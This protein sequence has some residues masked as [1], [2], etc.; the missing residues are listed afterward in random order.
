MVKA[1][2]YI[3]ERLQHHDIVLSYDRKLVSELADS[4]EEKVKS[5]ANM[6]AEAEKNIEQWRKSIRRLI[7]PNTKYTERVL[8]FKHADPSRISDG[9][10]EECKKMLVVDHRLDP[11]F[12][13]GCFVERLPAMIC[14]VRVLVM[15][16]HKKSASN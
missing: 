15:C 12:A 1:T 6:R 10:L 3:K 2:E 13:V 11:L 5:M 4:K 14:P 7:H 8:L 9:V 16:I